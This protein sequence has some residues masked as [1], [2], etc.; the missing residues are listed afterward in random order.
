VGVEESVIG[1]ELVFDERG[2]LIQESLDLNIPTE[3]G[4]PVIFEENPGYTTRG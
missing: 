2:L 3:S 4:R 1:E